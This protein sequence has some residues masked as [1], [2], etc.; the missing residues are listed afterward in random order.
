[1]LYEITI[2]LISSL[3]LKMA[4]LGHWVGIYFYGMVPQFSTVYFVFSQIFNQHFLHVAVFVKTSFQ[5]INYSYML[6]IWRPNFM[7][8][9]DR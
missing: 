2:S 4:V 6:R 1:M 8:F 5:H 9:K 7:K 3:L